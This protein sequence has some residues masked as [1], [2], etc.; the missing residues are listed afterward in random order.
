MISATVT[1]P[2]ALTDC[3]LSN[4]R[5]QNTIL[6]V[7]IQYHR[8]SQRGVRVGVGMDSTEGIKVSRQVVNKNWVWNLRKQL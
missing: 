1:K 8:Q 6:A 4:A 2:S 3:F 7:T 5:C